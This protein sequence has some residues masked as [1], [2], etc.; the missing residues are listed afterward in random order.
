MRRRIAISPRSTVIPATERADG[1][2]R[3]REHTRYNDGKPRHD[4]VRDEAEEWRGFVRAIMRNRSPDAPM[5]R[6]APRPSPEGFPW[7]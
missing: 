1:P 6:R 7:L 4:I 3:V 5:H 2:R